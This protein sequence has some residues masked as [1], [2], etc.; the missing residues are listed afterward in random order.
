[1]FDDNLLKVL[2]Q[3]V[4]IIL[5]LQTLNKKLPIWDSE[6]QSDGSDIVHKLKITVKMHFF[7]Q[8]VFG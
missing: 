5:D 4:D 6:S 7:D 8:S 3:H 2:I 1:M